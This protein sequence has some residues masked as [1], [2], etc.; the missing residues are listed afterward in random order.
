M[1]EGPVGG[2]VGAAGTS[3]ASRIASP[4]PVAVRSI[5]WSSAVMVS[6]AGETTT[7]LALTAEAVS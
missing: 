7:G 4:V 3:T 6:G 5:D 1:P 2:T